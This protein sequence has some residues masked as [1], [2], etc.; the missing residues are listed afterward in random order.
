MRRSFF[1][2][3]FS[4][5]ICF[6]QNMFDNPGFETWID[7]T[8]PAG[9]NHD[10]SILVRQEDVIVHSGNLS[11][12]DSLFTP[13]QDQADLWQGTYGI[14]P[15]NVYTIS[16]WILDNDP[17]AR[18][19]AGIWWYPTGSRW[20]NI[21]SADSAVWQEWIC[22]T[23]RAP[24]DAESATIMIRAYDVSANWDGDAIF[25]I[26]DAFFGLTPTPQPPVINRVWHTPINPDAGVMVEVYAK[27]SDSDG[28]ISADTLYYGVNSL[29]SPL[30]I[31]H[32][33]TS[34]DTFA[35]QIPGQALGDTVFYYL[36]FL[37]NDQLAAYSDTHVYYCGKLDVFINEILYDTYGTDA[38]CF[39]ELFHE[40]GLNL[41][42]FSLVAVDGYAGVEY[43]TISLGGYSIPLDGFFVIGDTSSVTNVD[44][45]DPFA[46]LQ[47]GPDN[48]E[49]RFNNIAIDGL[50]YGDPGTFFFTGE[51]LPARD[52]GP[53]TSLGRFPDGH[54]TDNNLVD[55]SVYA[56]PT[57]GAPNPDLRT[58][59][60]DNTIVRRPVFANP[61][62]SGIRFGSLI[63]GAG[64]YPLSIYNVAGRC[65]A[66]IATAEA[67]L[68]LA[69]GVYFLRLEDLKTGNAKIVVVR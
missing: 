63:A 14:Q 49:L 48:V 54:D 41:N 33:Q 27:A 20:V 64:A 35:Y 61:V 30:K 51:W 45:V 39:I 56:A 29:A 5:V 6:G 42:G 65:I 22:D 3:I 15:N 26:D 1:V 46:N 68:D 19:R 17:A 28:S 25:Y 24:A 69:P 13:Y 50:G 57:P 40:G 37:D 31:S 55:F 52:V 2:L 9:W 58:A 18:V 23:L 53:D 62:V 10:D 36:K 4:A 60:H 38:G 32:T 12:K 8:T 67:I 47:N 44:L 59:E 11:L 16:F 66:R 7:P 21:Y 34:N 43:D